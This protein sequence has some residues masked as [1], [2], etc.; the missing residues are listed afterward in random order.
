MSGTTA[1]ALPS[2]LPPGAPPGPRTRKISPRTAAS[3]TATRF[4]GTRRFGATSRGGTGSAAGRGS[5]AAISARPSA[6]RV[7]CA[8]AISRMLRRAPGTRTRAA[9]RAAPRASPSRIDACSAARRAARRKGVRRE[10]DREHAEEQIGPEPP[11]EI[12]GNAA[13][14]GARHGLPPRERIGGALETL[15]CVAQLLDDALEIEE[16]TF[17][18]D[19][20]LVDAALLRGHVGEDRFCVAGPEVERTERRDV[21]EER[22]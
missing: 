15:G 4:Q 21:T 8:S 2:G 22:A 14:R 17:A 7:S 9:A 6:R 11:G 3:T 19:G 1:L 13:V 16:L 18:L 12:E 5:R 20:A 10:E